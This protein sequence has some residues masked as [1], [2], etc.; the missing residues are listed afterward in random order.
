VNEL[1]IMLR[2]INIGI[3]TSFELCRSSIAGDG[4]QDPG[5]NVKHLEVY[6]ECVNSQGQGTSISRGKE[7]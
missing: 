7:G 6:T 3:L 2:V 4:F 1:S 5:H